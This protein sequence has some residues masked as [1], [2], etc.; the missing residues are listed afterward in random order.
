MAHMSAPRF[1]CL[2]TPSQ[3][4]ENIYTNARRINSQTLC[5]Q[6]GALEIG[7]ESCDFSPFQLLSQ[8]H[9]CPMKTKWKYNIG[10]ASWLNWWSWCYNH[11]IQWVNNI[12]VTNLEGRNIDCPDLGLFLTLIIIFFF[13]KYYLNFSMCTM[14][15]INQTHWQ[16]CLEN[17]LSFV[18]FVCGR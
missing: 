9:L 1:P 4:G 13:L 15:I 8:S 11:F 10:A 5:S 17:K 16:D 7:N 2:E 6:S 14:E 3:W 18:K 12:F